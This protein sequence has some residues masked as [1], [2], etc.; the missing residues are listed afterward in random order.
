MARYVLRRILLLPLS[1]FLLSLVCFGLRQITPG[2]PVISLM[3]NDEARLSND[4]P[5]AFDLA[6]R[7]A[8]QTLGLD[9][10]TFYFS[11]YNGALP[12]T[13]HRI[14]RAQERA[15]LRTF[16]LRSGNWLGVQ[17]YYHELR[18]LAYRVES[19]PAMTPIIRRLLIQ[20]DFE[21]ATITLQGLTDQPE[22][23]VLREAFARLQSRDYAAYLLVP[24]ISWHGINNQYHHW[25]SKIL[26]GDF[27]NSLMDRRPVTTKI[28][29]AAGVTILLNSL[30]LLLVFIISI[31]LGLYTAGARDSWFDR[32]TTVGLFIL[33]GVPSFWLATLLT[34]Y[35][36]TPAFSMD[37]FPSMGLG[38]LPEGASWWT[39]FRIRASHLFLPVVCMAYPSWAYV[40][41]HLRRSSL[42]ELNQAYIKTARLKGLSRST[43]LWRHVLRNASFPIIT[44]LGGI[45]PALLAGS[46]LIERIFNLPGMGQLLYTSAIERD[47]PIVI[48]LVLLNG[49]LTAIGLLIADLG[50]RLADPRIRLS[51]P[52]NAAS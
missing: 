52:Q 40:T 43:I 8:A 19:D 41:R 22:T 37:F 23:A 25:V 27:G 1:L 38:E 21:N 47:W 3:P 51:S 5:A 29:A 35:F 10:P 44:L 30:A 18:R 15:M 6:Y 31:P 28:K 16:T 7:R 45:F 9:R 4:D 36:T 39:A 34:N 33:F 48:T 17:Q 49:I 46:V 12:D 50:Y 24:A 20:D 11:V 2:D 42:H 26:S 32:L 13:L 14:T